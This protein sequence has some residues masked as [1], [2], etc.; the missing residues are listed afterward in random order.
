[1]RTLHHDHTVAQAKKH[2]SYVEYPAYSTSPFAVTVDLHLESLSG[3]TP[4]FS[5]T[6]SGKEVGGSDH[7]LLLKL[8]PEAKVVVAL[9]CST[10]DGIPMHAVENGFYYYQIFKG[11]ARH[12]DYKKDDG[13]RWFEVLCRH[14]RITPAKCQRL[15]AK[16]DTLKP[17]EQKMMFGAFCIEQRPRWKKEADQALAFIKQHA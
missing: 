14:L 1:M 16:L 13:T 10:E 12:H 3:Q 9:H 2:F 17:E 15:I 6:V 5:A 8:W 7:K 4:C 11:V